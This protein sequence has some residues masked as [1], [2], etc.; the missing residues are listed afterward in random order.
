MHRGKPV[1]FFFTRG[2][3]HDLVGADQLLPSMS[4]D[5]LIA[6]KAFDADKRVI[7]PLTAAGKTFVIPPKA[8]RLVNRDYDRQLYKNPPSNRELLCQTQAVPCHRHALR[9]NRQKLPRSYPLHRR[10]H[11]AQLTTRPSPGHP[12][13]SGRRAIASG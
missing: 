8:N 2:E 10:G 11:L 7:E 5:T 4:A 6:D 1:R 9:Q 3:A 13:G 12:A